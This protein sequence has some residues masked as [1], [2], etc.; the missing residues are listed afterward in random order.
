MLNL[1][2][3][4]IELKEKTEWQETPF[5]VAD[6]QYFRMI[7]RGLKRLFIDTGRAS[8]Y[9]PTKLIVLENEVYCYDSDFWIDEE[10]YILICSQ[11]IFFEKVQTD[12]NNSF[13][14]STDAITVTNADK[15]YANLKSTLDKLENERRITFHKMVRF[16]LGEG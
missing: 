5:P 6:S 12:V 7:L 9:D 10:E 14:Y 16:T 11:I 13:G 4:A 8:Q 15:P 2:E 3:L 1:T